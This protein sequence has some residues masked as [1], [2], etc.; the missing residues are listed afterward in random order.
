MRRLFIVL[1]ATL[2]CLA[3]LGC[4][5]KEGPA[6][7]A[8]KEIDKTVETLG[9]KIEDASKK[10][11]KKMEE[12]SDRVKKTMESVDDRIKKSTGKTDRDREESGEK[13][14]D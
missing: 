8:G 10:A 5:K 11:E 4:Q 7:R 6:E 2:L 1:F 12:A 3:A 13:E 9:S 14:K